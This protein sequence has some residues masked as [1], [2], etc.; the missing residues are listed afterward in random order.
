MTVILC[1]S[2]SLAQSG[3]SDQSSSPEPVPTQQEP[4]A[5]SR[6]PGGVG[7]PDRDSDR[8]AV[9]K[10]SD[11]DETP[12]PPKPKVTDNNPEF[13]LHVDVPVVT[14]DAHVLQKDGR[15]HSLPVD[16]AKEH[17]KI[18]EDGVPQKIQT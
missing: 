8:I 3:S 16:V 18:W 9:P 4:R 11:S 10:K 6:N 12:P 17:F 2:P 14:V 15:P 13:S 5:K 7:R 1:A